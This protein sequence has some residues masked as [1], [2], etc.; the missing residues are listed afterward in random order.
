MHSRTEEVLAYLDTQRAALAEA[1][2]AT[3]VA[4]RERRPAPDRW[5]IAEVL[6]HLAMV[7]GSINELLE[8]QVASARDAGLGGEREAGAAGSR[9]DPTLILDRSR[10]VQASE[11]FHPRGGIDAGAAQAKL[12]QRQQALRDML[13]GWDGLALHEVIVPHHVFGPL[14][15]Y[16]WVLFVA[17][18]EGRHA[19]Q[20]REIAAELQKEA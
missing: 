20:I 1:V 6:D 19:A 7:D 14:N 2:A 10:R 15:I 11:R 4:L 8:T 16:E 13:L 3:P 18:H 5:S 9:F 12:A 17:G